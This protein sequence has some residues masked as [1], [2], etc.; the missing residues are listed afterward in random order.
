M[1]FLLLSSFGLL[2]PV[3][4]LLG[5]NSATKPR[6][7]TVYGTIDTTV[8][9][10]WDELFKLGLEGTKQKYLGKN[11]TFHGLKGLGYGAK[12]EEKEN[13]FMQS[14]SF[15]F[16]EGV[17]SIS[18]FHGGGPNVFF[19]YGPEVMEWVKG[20]DPA[21]LEDFHDYLEVPFSVSAGTCKY[22]EGKEDCLAKHPNLYVTGKVIGLR[23]EGSD[24]SDGFI[25]YL[26]LRIYV[27]PIGVAY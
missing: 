6:Y 8:M 7:T 26:D 10:D 11:L 17:E 5:C 24:G 21:L 27:I 18:G 16:P 20:S 14:Y 22:I 15:V 4:S 13:A 3:L 12:N 25:P 19:N 9:A 2:F 1:R 23:V